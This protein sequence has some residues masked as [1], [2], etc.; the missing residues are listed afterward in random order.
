MSDPVFKIVL[1]G[2]DAGASSSVDKMVEKLNKAKE[3]TKRWNDERA[4]LARQDRTDKFRQ[5]SDEEKLTKL[6]ERQVQIEQ[7][8]A[9][10]T[11]DGNQVRES[12]LRLSAARN[13]AALSGLEGIGS[14]AS[15]DAS[16]GLI[17]GLVGRFGGPAAI[18]AAVLGIAYS[19]NKA[20]Q[21]SID[22]ADSIGD[23]ADAMQLTRDEVL[24]I[25]QQAT[26]AGVSNKALIGAISRFSTVRSAAQSG[27][28]SSIQLLNN[29]G[30]NANQINGT[31][32]S[33]SL[34]S[35]AVASLGSGGMQGQD[36]AALGKLFGMRPERAI[37]ALRTQVSDSKA[38]D[39]FKVLEDQAAFQEGAG[40]LVEKK[41][42][43]LSARL[44]NLLDGP[45]NAAKEI[46]TGIFGDEATSAA[47]PVL[48]RTAGSN[49]LGKAPKNKIDAAQLAQLGAIG[50]IASASGLARAGFSI[51]R[52]DP[53]G[54]GLM[55]KQIEW[56]EKI[57]RE[58]R[59]QKQILREGLL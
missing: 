26:A 13:K 30:I 38:G 36:R 16:G 11:R 12:A 29:Y 47:L 42:A 48:K 40:F 35:K 14:Q 32:S 46:F 27:D 20:V 5:L 58:S 39:A 17:S 10:A 1:Q 7:R 25:A 19:M 18:G 4:K 51:G 6:K 56:T 8:L 9:R 15:G 3:T 45:I 53:E 34:A 57:Y 54:S 22:F 50:Q 49:P 41:K 31:E 52:N 24:K 44:L 28:A 59:E 2:V 55:R 43:E 21:S 37:A 33:Y 23:T